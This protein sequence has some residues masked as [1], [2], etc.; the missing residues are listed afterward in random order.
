MFV[1]AAIPITLALLGLA[2][3]AS[4]PVGRLLVAAG[5]VLFGPGYIVWSLVDAELRLPRLAAPALW[6]SLSL[7]IVPLLFLWSSTLGL[8][9]TPA[10]LRGQ[11]LGIVLLAGWCWQRSGSRRV[12]LWLLGSWLGLLLLVAFTRAVEIRGVVLPLWVDSLHHTLLARIVAETGRIPTSLE[13]YMP[14]DPLVYH[15]GY[16]TVIATLKVV[17]AL[18]IALAVLWGGQAL[19][20]LMAVTMY[21]VASFLLR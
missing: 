11:A 20:A 10:V 3:F 12:P 1:R 15:W 19:N 6:L 8:R 5:I 17:A 21:G 14:V 9:L 4:G 16:H 2:L 18:P 7:C 13:P